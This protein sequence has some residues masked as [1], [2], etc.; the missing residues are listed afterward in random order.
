M[1]RHVRPVTKVKGQM[2]RSQG[3]VTYKQQERYNQAT[4]MVVSTSNLVKIF[5]VRYATR[6]TLS[7]SVGRLDRK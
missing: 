7:R 5:I 6:A 1:T 3:H 2:S 4:Y